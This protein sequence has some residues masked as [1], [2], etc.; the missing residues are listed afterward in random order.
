MKRYDTKRTIIFISSFTVN[1]NK[2]K[3]KLTIL[4]TFLSMERVIVKQ[5]YPKK[6]KIIEKAIPF[7]TI[8]IS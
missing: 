1:K 3:L 2:K 7:K 5:K 4:Y 8:E 6:Q